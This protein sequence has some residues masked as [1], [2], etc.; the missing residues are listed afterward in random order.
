[1]NQS[2]KNQYSV[3]GKR[4][5]RFGDIDK[6]TGRTKFVHDIYLPDMLYGKI[7]RSM[8]PHARIKSMNVEQAKNL[9][10]VEAVLTSKDI[11]KVYYGPWV[12]DQLVFA[13]EIVRYIGEPIA[14]V[15]AETE[16]IAEEALR[17]I[18]VEYE[19]L[20]AVFDV[21]EA[22][23]SD[24]VIIHPCFNDY[25][26]LYP[27]DLSGHGCNVTSHTSFYHGDVE[28]GFAEADIVVEEKFKTQIH[29]QCYLERRIAIADFSPHSGDLTVWASAQSPF[30]TVALLARVMETPISKIRVITPPVGGA[31]GGKANPLLEPH[32]AFLSKA[33]GKPVRIELTREEDFA[34]T[35]PRHATVLWAK[36]GAKK[37]GTFTAFQLKW[38]LDSGAYAFEGPAVCDCGSVFGRGPYW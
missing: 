2:D 34:A 30:L 9:S 14:A 36:I 37:D 23:T 31:F 4:N 6:A 1:M 32:A 29:H 24:K 5:R 16:D 25:W 33:A 10:G 15:A 18:D 26:R 17:L 21:E 19:E 12:R 28:K 27:E 8:M 3:I 11:P 7:L 22:F 20:P 13:D 38:I 35:N